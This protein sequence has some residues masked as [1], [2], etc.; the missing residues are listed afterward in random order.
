VGQATYNEGIWRLT[1]ALGPRPGTF[2]VV[3]QVS[4]KAHRLFHPF[5]SKR[6]LMSF[7]AALSRFAR[8]RPCG[9]PAALLVV[10]S[11]FVAG[12]GIS[13]ASACPFCSAV[14]QTL[15]QEMGVMDAV[16]IAEATDQSVRDEQTGEV[17]LKVVSVLKGDDLIKADTDVRVVYFGKIE[18]GR[19]FMLSGVDPPNLQWSSLPLTEESEAYVR[20]IP[21]LPDDGLER[22]KFYQNFLQHP[23]SMLTRDSYDEFAITPY[24]IVQSLKPYMDREQLIEWI[25]EPEMPADRKRL[26]FTMLGVCGSEKD[27]PMLE[28]MLTSTQ[29]SSRSG[30]DALVACYLILAGEEGLE[31]IDKLFLANKQAPYADT[32]AAIMAIRF[33]GTEAD[34]IPRSA[35]VQSLHHVLERKDLADLVIPDLARWGDWSQIDRLVELFIDAEEDNNWVRVPVVNYLRACPKPEA[36]A[37]LEKLR[38]IDPESVRRAS[39]FFSIPIPQAPAQGETS[40]NLRN[41]DEALLAISA[42]G[43]TFTSAGG[44]KPPAAT[45][46]RALLSVSLLAVAAMCLASYLVLTGGGGSRIAAV[47]QRA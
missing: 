19:R 11:L 2:G 37:A 26:Y 17:T 1:I 43:V 28:K 4:A 47:L 33:H 13:L 27:V 30:L 9:R 23:D 25:Q 12:P 6:P 46:P 22:L 24:P 8:L 18:P 36:E 7:S 38:E 15:R 10:A 35:L 41:D 42:A 20:K 40:S 5:T 16:V 32:Y 14:S 44:T 39:S 3:P 29:P 31:V 45:N 34:K 21:E